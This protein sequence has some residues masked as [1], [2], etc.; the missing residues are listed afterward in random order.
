M[1]VSLTPQL[2]QYVKDKVKSGRYNASSQVVREASC[3]MGAWDTLL[4]PRVGL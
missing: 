3:P 1:N 4:R 2:E